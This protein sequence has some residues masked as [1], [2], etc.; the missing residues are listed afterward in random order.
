MARQGMQ[1]HLMTSAL[2]TG[3]FGLVLSLSSAGLW[4]AQGQASLPAGADSKAEVSGER[5]DRGWFFFKDPPKPVEPEQEPEQEQPVAGPSAPPKKAEDPC[6]SP[7]TWKPSCGFLDPGND[8]VF[9]ERMRDELLQ[10][11][12]LS[13]QDPKAVEAVQYYVKWVMGKSV[14]V[15]RMWQYNMTQ[16]P[17]LDPF[18]Q[19][20]ITSFGLKLMSEVKSGETAEIFG[21]LREQGAFFVYFTRSDCSFCHSM[22]PTVA[23]LAADAGIPVRNAA[24]D[25]RCLTEF[26]DGC[27]TSADTLAP[28]QALQ[29]SIVPALFL[30]VPDNT[31]LRL[32]T[33]VVDSATLSARTVSFFSAY[34]SALLKGIQNGE[35]ARAPV[36]FSVDSA[37]GTASG[38]APSESPGLPSPEDIKRLFGGA[39]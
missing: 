22:A 24:L 5:S 3:V 32:G 25:D 11:M 10:H 34:R 26:K 36:D 8:F 37:S 19:Q 33:G 23:R 9:Q 15:A 31:W 20:P 21:A 14:Q 7:K 16:N 2:R 39:P 27:L 38:V 18:V 30:Y 17:E 6:K 29:V 28:A 13:N 12:S 4:A 1:I 35:G